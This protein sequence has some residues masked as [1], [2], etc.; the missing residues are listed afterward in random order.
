[1]SKSDHYKALENMYLA[2]PINKI[3]PPTLAVGE[4][5]AEV[6]LDIIPDYFHTAQSLHGSVYFKMLDDSA[7]FAAQSAVDDVFVFT[8]K[9]TTNIRKPVIK[10]RVRAEGKIDKIDGKKIFASSIMYDENGDE[11]ASG[12]GLFLPSK[13]PLTAIPEYKRQ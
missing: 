5:K 11:V 6:S 12:E 4:H 2:A 7:F 1:M 9:F 3:F 8:V 10:G 13:S